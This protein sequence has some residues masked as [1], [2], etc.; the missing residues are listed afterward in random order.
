LVVCYEKS[1][2]DWRNDCRLQLKKSRA[3]CGLVQG[4]AE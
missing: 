4:R 2:T 3:G 1:K